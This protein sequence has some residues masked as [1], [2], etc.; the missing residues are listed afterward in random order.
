MNDSRN[1]GGRPG[2]RTTGGGV[3]PRSDDGADT[4]AVVPPEAARVWA[5][6]SFLVLKQENRRAEVEEA[7]GLSFFR[8]KALRRLLAGPL[9][10]RELTDRLST[11]KPYTTLVVDELERR[12]YVERSVHPVDR[13]S[14]IVSLTAAGTAAAERAESI[15]T[16]PPRT[17][18]A[19]A[20]E[21]LTVLEHIMTKLQQPQG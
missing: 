3:E 16:R 19:L 2:T 21:E 8:V 15:L 14:K 7:L 1:D 18:L 9:T 10:M 5:A 11:D 6:M 13:R 4:G 17:L 20:P 12:G